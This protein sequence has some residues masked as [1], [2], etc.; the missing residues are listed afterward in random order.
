M[1]RRVVNGY[2]SAHPAVVRGCSEGHRRGPES[3]VLTFRK[4]ESTV[5]VLIKI[6]TLVYERERW[7]I[8]EPW[9]STLFDLAE[10][11]GQPC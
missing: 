8:M 6:E 4:G 3:K 7:P 5:T 10:Q 1:S 2:Q 11:V 9:R